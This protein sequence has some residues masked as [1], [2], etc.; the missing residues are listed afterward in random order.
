MYVLT[1]SVRQDDEP[2][3]WDMLYYAAHMYEDGEMDTDAAKNNPDLQKYVRG[4]GRETDVG[5]L[6]L[7]P[8]NQRPL[9]AAWLRVLIEERKCR[10]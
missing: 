5:V 4:W 6:A 7:H 1:R 2:F 8:S 10:A 9:G 3:L